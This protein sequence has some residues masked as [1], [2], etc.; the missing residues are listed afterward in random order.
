M[1]IYDQAL[2]TA[3]L[4]A[5]S[6]PG[7]LNATLFVVD[8]ALLGVVPLTERLTKVDG[9]GRILSSLRPA[10]VVYIPV[11]WSE[12]YQHWCTALLDFNSSTIWIYDPLHR[13]DKIADTR[14]LVT[15]I[16]SELV[17]PT[18]KLQVRIFGGLQQRGNY[19]CGLLVTPFLEMYLL[20]Q[21]DVNTILMQITAKELAY[22][23]YRLFTKLYVANSD[24]E[25]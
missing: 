18:K 21:G 25:D 22:S 13:D 6:S 5:G 8:P 15:T 17:P 20:A 3:C 10:S 23:R 1:L 4:I 7:S 24:M 9:E 2:Y 14:R 12:D 19:N 16:T 11:N